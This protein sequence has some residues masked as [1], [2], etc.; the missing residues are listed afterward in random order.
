MPTRREFIQQSAALSTLPFLPPLEFENGPFVTPKECDPRVISIKGIHS[1]G[2]SN[3]DDKS[4]GVEFGNHLRFFVGT[5]HGLPDTLEVF[6]RPA[7]LRRNNL[8]GFVIPCEKTVLIKRLLT[9]CR[10]DLTAETSQTGLTLPAS[11]RKSDAN[12]VQ[13]SIKFPQVVGYTSITSIRDPR[14]WRYKKNGK[15]TSLFS[16]L[17][18]AP[19]PDKKLTDDAK[20]ARQPQPARTLHVQPV[21][22]RRKRTKFP[23]E[24]VVQGIGPFKG[25]SPSRPI[26]L[27][28]LY[29]GELVR[30]FKVSSINKR[31]INYPFDELRIDVP[32][33]QGVAVE[34][35]LMENDSAQDTWAKFETIPCA[36]KILQE[37]DGAT[38]KEATFQRLVDS[39][40]WPDVNNRFL[41]RTNESSQSWT[42]SGTTHLK[43]LYGGPLFLETLRQIKE[44][45]TGPSLI[46]RVTWDQR[47]DDLAQHRGYHLGFEVRDYNEEEL[48]FLLLLALD[49]NIATIIG[50]HTVDR[51]QPLDMKS[52]LELKPYISK[53]TN[54]SNAAWDYKVEGHWAHLSRDHGFIFYDLHASTTPP[55]TGEKISKIDEIEGVEIIN[56]VRNFKVGL[57]WDI[58]KD[59]HLLHIIG[60]DVYRNDKLIKPEYPITPSRS[61]QPVVAN[62]VLSRIHNNTL[63]FLPPFS[64]QMEV[65][66]PAYVFVDDTAPYGGPHTY[67]VESVDIHGRV[68]DNKI[69]SPPFTVDQD[70]P[71]PPPVDLRSRV[72]NTG[73]TVTFLNRWDWNEAQ[74]ALAPDLQRFDL[75][76]HDGPH[77]VP[78]KGFMSWLTQTSA[79]SAEFNFEALVQKINDLDFTAA[80]ASKP[81]KLICGGMKFSVT[82]IAFE[83]R[84]NVARVSGKI[85]AKVRGGLGRLAIIPS[86]TRC[87]MFK[88]T[89]MGVRRIPLLTN[90]DILPVN[91]NATN[92]GFDIT[93]NTNHATSIGVNEV[94]I[95]GIQSF[96]LAGTITSSSSPQN[97][98]P[99]VKAAVR[100]F[101]PDANWAD[102]QLP[103]LETPCEFFLDD[104]DSWVDRDDENNWTFNQPLPKPTPYPLTTATASGDN[105]PV[106]V[107]TV[108]PEVVMINDSAGGVDTSLSHIRAKVV[109]FSTSA[110]GFLAGCKLS[111][112]GFDQKIMKTTKG[113][114]PQLLISVP[115]STYTQATAISDL[116]GQVGTISRAANTTI[117]GTCTQLSTE[118]GATNLMLV[119][120]GAVGSIDWRLCILECTAWG[121]NLTDPTTIN[122]ATA[123]AA[124]HYYFRIRQ[125]RVI[126]STHIEVEV[127]NIAF[128]KEVTFPGMSIAD[129][130]EFEVFPQLG[131]FILHI[132][133]LCVGKF[134]LTGMTPADHTFYWQADGGEVEYALPI[135]SSEP[136]YNPLNP[137]DTRTEHSSIVAV[138]RQTEG[139]SNYLYAAFYPVFSPTLGFK[140]PGSAPLSF[141][142]SFRLSIAH[143][144]I[145]EPAIRERKDFFVSVRAVAHDGTYQFKGNLANAIKPLVGTDVL[146]NVPD[147]PQPLPITLPTAVYADPGP[148]GSVYKL[149]WNTIAGAFEYK[150]YRIAKRFIDSIANGRPDTQVLN[151]YSEVKEAI[152]LRNKSIL[153]E[154]TF[155]DVI[156][157]R[158]KG[159]YYYKIVPVDKAGTPITATQWRNSIIIPDPV[160]NGPLHVLDTIPP[161]KPTIQ[162]AF[163]RDGKVILEFTEDPRADE[164]WITRESAE[165]GTDIT[166]VPK[167]NLTRVPLPF[168]NEQEK[169]RVKMIGTE[170]VLD[171][172]WMEDMYS[173][174]GI[175][176]AEDYWKWLKDNTQVITNY[177]ITA[178]PGSTHTQVQLVHR[179]GRLETIYLPNALCATSQT[180]DGKQL[181]V[182]YVV[183]KTVEWSSASTQITSGQI[184]IAKKPQVAQIKGIFDTRNFDPNNYAL[185]SSFTFVQDP[186]EVY[187]VAHTIKDSSNHLVADTVRPVLVYTET[188]GATSNKLLFGYSIKS[189]RIEVVSPFSTSLLKGE[190]AN[191]NFQLSPMPVRK[192]RV[193]G[194]H[195]EVLQVAQVLAVFNVEEFD[196]TS[197]DLASTL[198]FTADLTS[199]PPVIHSIKDCSNNPVPEGF[200]SIVIYTDTTASNASKKI[201][202][203]RPVRNGRIQGGYSFDNLFSSGNFDGVSV[204]GL[205]AH[206]GKDVIVRIQQFELRHAAFVN[207]LSVRLEGITQVQSIDAIHVPDPI[208]KAFKP[209]DTTITHNRAADQINFDPTT[210]SVSLPIPAESI[211]TYTDQDGM[212]RS[213]KGKLESVNSSLAKIDTTTLFNS[214]MKSFEG[215]W[216]KSEYNHASILPL[217]ELVKKRGNRYF[218]IQRTVVY[219]HNG[220]KFPICNSNGLIALVA[221]YTDHHDVAQK[222]EAVPGKQSCVD[223]NALPDTITNYGLQAAIVHQI[224][225]KR[226]E[227]P[228]ATSDQKPVQV[229]SPNI[230]VPPQLQYEGLSASGHPEFSWAVDPTIKEYKLQRS[231]VNSQNWQAGN[232]VFRNEG[233]VM[234]LVQDEWVES[235]KSYRYRLLVTGRNNKT[236]QMFQESQEIRTQ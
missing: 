65:K 199:Q 82:G 88:K 94:V 141:F 67:A 231:E 15:Y 51:G 97:P 14:A 163:V 73:G 20:K 85:K 87:M 107:S 72:I 155:T 144:M 113:D 232:R 62:S 147:L 52:R 152:S 225:S 75:F 90:T 103:Y 86:G 203:G 222:I 123:P 26:A 76:V 209:V 68:S 135:Q 138:S 229:S 206:N 109:D 211:I 149:N 221:R 16:G 64:P 89:A 230:P 212:K 193:V 7:S 12:T 24:Y 118:A 71:V 204:N 208:A 3:G 130:V 214:E 49:V 170:Q 60:Y 101:E 234:M 92:A 106:I 156:E 154:T 21:P 1:D 11:I 235:N 79:D 217:K 122:L 57:N 127:E 2:K 38:D 28:C 184:A 173:V 194:V 6:R 219:A 93:L 5:D 46:Q 165:Y 36:K 215:I 131:N 223:I 81:E 180:I 125:A 30:K 159:D 218:Q 44:A 59:P 8:I 98:Y 121:T 166:K 137:T 40:F 153:K 96:T 110:S 146:A 61:E 148:L 198:Q 186:A 172:F 74:R 58:D 160:A 29:Q 34:F 142:P 216:R 129:E 124:T 47:G 174:S 22:A 192:D 32:I 95:I 84:P 139:G 176:L 182:E 187:A 17:T 63:P 120:S 114:D 104:R 50:L 126:D 35:V 54:I 33:K 83:N 18:A 19:V 116:Q 213:A 220:L 66:A 228:S 227:I 157:S 196:E 201:M 27:V 115:S 13:F 37:A 210:N 233:Q 191:P 43:T 105:L 134:A 185:G 119:S 80:S 102:H 150:V 197:Y 55:M 133:K 164:Y 161:D 205:S 190:S 158:G 112:A 162:N 39:R 91:L 117:T 70:V 168:G 189:G 69:T 145:T 48:G 108:T 207:Y 100:R 10:V 175:Y 200:R 128:V 188:A 226:I 224:N 25:T 140:L 179:S 178:N 132:P 78:C 77:H 167:A 143:A 181:S 99:D 195:E 56:N 31:I 151:I 45:L 23:K 41:H 136:G 53:F 4:N 202:Y 111:K 171:L 42:P 236:N 9:D 183:E 169:I 177:Y